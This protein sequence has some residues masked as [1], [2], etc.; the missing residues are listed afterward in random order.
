MRSSDR[1]TGWTYSE[2]NKSFDWVWDYGVYS[3]LKRVFTGLDPFVCLFF[4]F[5]FFCH[6][7]VHLLEEMVCIY[8]TSPM[9]NRYELDQRCPNLFLCSPQL[10]QINNAIR[11]IS[12]TQQKRIFKCQIC[13]SFWN[14]F[15]ILGPVFKLFWCFQVSMKRS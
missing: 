13:L 5:G 15:Y 4:I 14:K 9:T 6:W 11:H 8:S 7:V 12:V 2:S 1:R 10:C 3:F